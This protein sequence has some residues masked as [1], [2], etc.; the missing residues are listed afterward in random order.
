MRKTV[1]AILLVL[2]GVSTAESGVL[3]LESGHHTWTDAN[4]HYDEVWLLNDASLDFVGGSMGH[5][6]TWNNSMADI[7]GGTMDYLCTYDNSVVNLHSGSWNWM[8]SGNASAVYLYAYNV[9]HDPT[10]GS[11]GDGS[12]EGYFYK[13]DSQFSFSLLNPG[14]YPHIQIVPEPSSLALLALGSLLLRLRR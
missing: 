13:D 5:L 3:F 7:D 12:L 14:T 8:V 11:F 1:L 2:A 6:D 9:T 10:G 4:D